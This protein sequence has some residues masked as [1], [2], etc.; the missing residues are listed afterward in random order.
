MFSG[1]P[2]RDNC[3]KKEMFQMKCC[4]HKTE[5]LTQQADDIKLCQ[6]LDCTTSAP[7]SL[8]SAQMRPASL[9][10]VLK[11][12]PILQFFSPSNRKKKC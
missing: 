5:S 2:L 12:S 7:I 11:T 9:L 10:V 6:T 4:K 1:T 8:N 3:V